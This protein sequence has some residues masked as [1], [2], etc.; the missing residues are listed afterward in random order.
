MTKCCSEY[1]PCWTKVPVAWLFA[2]PYAADFP[3]IYV[4]RIFE[5]QTGYQAR[6]VLG[7]NCRFLQYRGPHAKDIHEYV[8]KTVTRKM[9]AAISQ[10]R[11]FTGEVL[12]FDKK[13]RP[14]TTFLHL[15]PLFSDVSQPNLVTH[16]AGIQNFHT[17]TYLKLPEMRPFNPSSL[18]YTLRKNVMTQKLDDEDP[19]NSQLGL[20][21]LDYVTFPHLGLTIE[22]L[23]QHELEGILKY[24]D[25]QSLLRLGATNKHMHGCV[26]TSSV[27]HNLCIRAWG[28]RLTNSVT[29]F[30]KHLG[31]ERV[32]KELYTLNAVTWR[33]FTVGGT[34]WPNR[35]NFSTCSVGHKVI[36]FGGEAAHAVPLD[37]TYM[38]DLS[39]E[40]PSWTPLCQLSGAVRP[41]GRWGHTLRRLGEHTVIL[42]GGCGATGPLTDVYVID[43]NVDNP[44]WQEVLPSSRNPH[45]C[46]RSWHGCCCTSE[47]SMLIFSGC[48]VTGRL[49]YDTWQLDLSAKPPI[50]REIPVAWNPSGRLGLSV[51]PLEDDTVV[52]FGG[53]ASAG[54]V[55][56]RSNDCFTLRNFSAKPSD[57]QPPTWQY[58]S[59]S[60]LP[61]GAETHGTPPSPRLEQVIGQLGGGRVIVF[62]GSVSAADGMPFSRPF[63]CDVNAERP[64]WQ[65]MDVKGEGPPQAWGYSAAVMDDVRFILPGYERGALLFNELY[66][67]SI[68]TPLEA[69]YGEQQQQ[70]QQPAQ[71]PNEIV[72]VHRQSRS[73]VELPTPLPNPLEMPDIMRL[74]AN[75]VSSHY[76]GPS[77][78][79]ETFNGND[80]YFHHR[81][82]TGWRSQQH[83][84]RSSSSEE[85]VN[86]IAAPEHP[87]RP[88][89]SNGLPPGPSSFVP[90]PISQIA[91]PFSAGVSTLSYPQ[92]PPEW[93]TTD[94][95]A[96]DDT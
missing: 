64:T 83:S 92:S 27:W 93:R 58:I 8:D 38:L 80:L 47:D 55:R 68:L 72:N 15:F 87:L 1:S 35:T 88:E 19:E 43:I 62:G 32:V 65:M 26:H 63:I 96:M 14:L 39:Q 25:M 79:N 50:W 37:D 67:L 45:P 46:P 77:T 66:E 21:E 90:I 84:L 85:S 31:W 12:N 78:S 36:L 29:D 81:P 7:R 54:P 33:S 11:E 5:H 6:E 61:S 86:S 52:M 53:L 23:S 48:D 56:L 41:P 10:G 73:P 30:S 95:D 74:A 28:P 42:F 59:G 2:M 69:L 60:T 89:P 44:T 94:S 34:V 16:Y 18:S 70:Q 82:I 91:T 76:A 3:V 17:V 57:D 20:M 22:D 51:V 9:A 4:N 71:R 75:H 24:L 49:L 13:G 40:A